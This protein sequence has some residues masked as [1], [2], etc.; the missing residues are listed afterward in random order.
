M[1]VFD[2]IAIVI[3]AAGSSSRMGQPK[4]LL[5]WKNKSFILRSVETALSLAPERTLVVLGSEQER[6]REEIEDSQVH[7][8][9][10]EEWE[11]GMGRSISVGVDYVQSNWPEVFGILIML[12]DQPLI[13]FEHLR[14]LMMAL[15]RSNCGMVATSHSDE[16]FGVPAIFDSRYFDELRD[17]N[18]DYGARE[19]IK[20]H[21]NRACLVYGYNKVIDLDTESDYEEF[22]KA[23]PQS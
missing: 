9:F 10:N 11:A 13:D 17:L 18:S 15:K 14:S 5:K 3:L 6:I 19:L 2:D 1:D 12:S 8:V 16:I 4:Q 22:L 7:M 23:N 21:C 20:T